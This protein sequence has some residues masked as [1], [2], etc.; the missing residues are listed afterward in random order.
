MAM[1]NDAAAFST[2]VLTDYPCAVRRVVERIPLRDGVELSVKLWLPEGEA[3]PA[4]TGVVLEAIPYRKDDV[5]L[6]DDE[7]RFAYYA[8]FGIAGARLDLR[9]SGTSTGLPQDEYSTIEQA[10][11]VEAVQ[12]LSARPWCNG[13]VGMMGISWSGFNALQVAARRPEALKALITVCSTDDRYDNDV[14]YSGGVPLAFYMNLWGSALH[15]MNMRPPNPEA[16]GPDWMS[17]WVDRLH[18]NQ[19]STSL[20]LAHPH[21]DAYWRQA[22]S[23]RTTG[24][25]SARCSPSAAGRTPTPTRC[26]AAREPD[27]PV[28]AVIGP[29]PHLAGR[30]EPAPHRLPRAQPALVAP[31]ALRRPPG[32]RTTRV[33]RL[34]PGLHAP[35]RI[36]GAPGSDRRRGPG[37]DRPRAVLPLDALEAWRRRP[38]PWRAA[39]RP[40]R[41]H[42]REALPADG[43]EHRPPPAQDRDDARCLLQTEPLAEPLTVLGR[44]CPC[45]CARTRRPA[46]LRPDHRRRPTGTRTSCAGRPH[47]PTAAATRRSRSPPCRREWV[48]VEVP[49]K[50]TGYR[51]A[52]GHR[53]RVAVSPHYWPW[54]WP[55][56]DQVLEIDLARSALRLRP[57]ARP[58]EIPRA[59]WAAGHRPAPA[60]GFV[61]EAVP[62]WVEGADGEVVVRGHR[63]ESDRAARR[64]ELRDTGTTTS[65][66]GGSAT[67]RA[68]G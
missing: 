25:S 1:N 9:G 24:R 62:Y 54:L 47:L 64:V 23:A 49:L 11:I 8:G 18:A 21:R 42:G 41:R 51:L 13:S 19:D 37:G 38:A 65:T 50:S 58:A 6:L 63:G 48:D 4:R 40:R 55:A 60:D 32:S 22:R 34:R 35:A 67:R 33:P 30:P 68:P 20:W 5:S 2:A 39:R 46:G 31:V 10:D 29:W 27:A 61:G 53:L 52:A 3:A 28:Q 44:L 36:R 56:P 59:T 17:A 45:A 7:T 14:H 16:M 12:W 15:L 43:R 57:G 26:T 66:R